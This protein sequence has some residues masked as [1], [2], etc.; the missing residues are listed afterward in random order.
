MSKRN[1][2]G[3]TSKDSVRYAPPGGSMSADGGGVVVGVRGI[4]WESRWRGCLLWCSPSLRQL[5]LG[6]GQPRLDSERQVRGAQPGR[7]L[8]AGEGGLGHGLVDGISP[9]A[10]QARRQQHQTRP[11]AADH[12]RRRPFDVW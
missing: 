11:G 6:A 8:I 7:A 10:D 9:A 4:A 3:L 2:F 5:G 12:Q 1:C